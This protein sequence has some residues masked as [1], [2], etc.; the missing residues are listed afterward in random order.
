MTSCSSA[1]QVCWEQCH[2]KELIMCRNARDSPSAPTIDWGEKT[3]QKEWW[4]QHQLWISK[5]TN[6]NGKCYHMTNI[7]L[8]TLT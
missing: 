6:E 8:F 7:V 2:N 3:T 1:S 5:E 4:S